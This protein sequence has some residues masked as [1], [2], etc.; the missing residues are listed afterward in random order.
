MFVHRP[1]LSRTQ[2]G[3]GA[4]REVADVVGLEFAN[5]GFAVG[6]EDGG[7]GWASLLA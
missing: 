4:R 7:V 1:S 6:G 5:G 2:F 3:D